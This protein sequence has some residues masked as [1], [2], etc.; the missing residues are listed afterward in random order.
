[1]H[2]LDDLIV[3]HERLAHV[4]RDV[5]DA[6]WI[7]DDGPDAPDL[8]ELADLLHEGAALLSAALSIMASS[9]HD[10]QDNHDHVDAVMSW[11]SGI[12]RHATA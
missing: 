8:P 4:A 10:T 11:P 1:M 5:V 6:A 3:F 12:T 2:G 7:A 9:I